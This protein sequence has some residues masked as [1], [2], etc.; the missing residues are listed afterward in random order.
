MSTALLPWLSFAV[1]AVQV[2]ACFAVGRP[3][4][5][6][7]RTRAPLLLAY[8]GIPF[9]FGIVLFLI[10]IPGALLSLSFGS[11]SAAFDVR[12]LWRPWLRGL[13]V[14]LSLCV[15]YYGPKD[16]A[17]RRRRKRAPT[18]ARRRDVA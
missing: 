14:G 7:L 13:G 1:G 8:R 6:L 2:L 16:I 4:W 12:E 3:L 15:L 10:I 18:A 17:E 11:T 5:P 9:F